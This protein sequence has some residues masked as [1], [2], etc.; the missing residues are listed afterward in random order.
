MRA[1]LECA[2][3]P[4]GERYWAVKDPVALKYFH[5]REEEYAI[6]SM[7]DGRASLDE[8]RQRWS[9]RFAPRLLSRSKCTAF[10][11]RCTA[12][13]WCWPR[14]PGRASNCWSA[15]TISRAS[16][17]TRR[18]WDCWRF[19]FAASTRVRLLD[20]LDPSSAGCFRRLAS[21]RR[22]LLALAAALLVTVQFDVFRARLPEF[23]TILS[24]REPA[25]A[26]PDDRR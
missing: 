21:R 1:D 8:I 26:G 5:L 12:T 24:A 17:A 14:R 11:P 9:K 22:L 19:A 20:W 18:C 25:L 6:L 13:A 3:R 16:A 15:A 23:R 2:R 10:W 4:G 7:L